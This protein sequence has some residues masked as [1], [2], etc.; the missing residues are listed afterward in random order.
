MSYSVSSANRPGK[1]PGLDAQQS[2]PGHPGGAISV[3]DFS[4]E[5]LTEIQDASLDDIQSCINNGNITWVHV[6]KK[7]STELLR[8]L[9]TF[10]QLHPLAIED[11]ANLRQRPKLEMYDHGCFVVV[12][13]PVL[14]GS[15][16]SLEQISLF[17]GER[18]VLSFHEGEED[19]FEPVQRRLRG[20]GSGRIR[21][22]G[23][24]YL[25]YALI[26]LVVDSAFPVIDELGDRL[27]ELEEQVLKEPKREYLDD[28]HGMRRKL[29]MLRRGLAPQ[30]EVL[31]T[32]IRDD[33]PYIL[34]PTK[35][36]LRDS[37]D[38]TL[39]IQEALESFRELVLNTQEIYMSSLGMRMNEI[40]K[41]LTI[42]ATIF[43]PLS[44]ITGLYGMNFNT[45]ISPWNMPELNAYFGYPVLL[46]VL[47]IAITGMLIYFRLRD[48]L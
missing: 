14:C 16:A 35:I 15:D 48:W 46:L 22:R 2:T 3:F 25:L 40:M 1:S 26:D 20:E 39:R 36:F 13:L 18:Y 32:M 30:R 31:N 5:Q 43:I 33:H 47:T 38:H 19:V 28:L 7:P 23:S 10:F 29:I 24:D 34:E 4:P 27:E 21:S 37:Y 12:H 6:Q 41:V 17:L 9:A 11:V 8:T 42:I 44:F 45:Q